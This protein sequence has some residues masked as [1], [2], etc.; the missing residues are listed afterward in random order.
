M[1]QKN[2]K[3]VVR[4]NLSRDNIRALKGMVLQRQDT[5][6]L[7]IPFDFLDGDELTYK[8]VAESPILG[9]DAY[10]DV[11]EE[12]NTAVSL[13]LIAYLANTKRKSNPYA[14]GDLVRV[15]MNTGVWRL[16]GRRIGHVT[17]VNSETLWVCLHGVDSHTVKVNKT[18]VE[19]YFYHH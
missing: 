13:F 12:L 17:R 18:D 5:L 15:R 3:L 10:E 11:I 16:K 6:E 19:P 2:S 9:I 8:Y 7:S 1:R 14:I 4:I